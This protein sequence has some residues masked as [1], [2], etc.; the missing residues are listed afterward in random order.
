MIAIILITGAPSSPGAPSDVGIFQGSTSS[1][2]R[3]RDHS[4]DGRSCSGKFYI[5][6]AYYVYII[7]L[8]LNIFLHYCDNYNNR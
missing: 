6:L 7:L 3:Y 4:Q 2:N 1:A 8:L 5:L